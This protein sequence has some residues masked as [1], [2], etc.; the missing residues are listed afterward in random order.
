MGKNEEGRKGNRGISSPAQQC[1]LRDTEGSCSLCAGI[2]LAI[3]LKLWGVFLST[4]PTLPPFLP[5]LLVMTEQEVGGLVGRGN[6]A[7]EPEGRVTAPPPGAGWVGGRLSYRQILEAPLVLNLTHIQSICTHRTVYHLP[8]SPI[9]TPTCRT[10]NLVGTAMP[11]EHSGK[12]FLV[13][14]A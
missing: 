6:A 10:G 1:R 13:T 7:R 5:K 3:L 12:T 8:N 11:Q 14:V 9:H 4:A 2:S